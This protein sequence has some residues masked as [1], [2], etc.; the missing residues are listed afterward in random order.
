MPI[1]TVYWMLIMVG[2]FILMFILVPPLRGL[3]LSPFGF[4]LG[5]VQA[6]VLLWFGQ[7]YLKVFYFIGDPTFLGVPLLTSLTWIPLVILF[8][9]YFTKSHSRMVKLLL[10]PLFS[11]GTGMGQYTIEIIGLFQSLRWSPVYTFF[12]ALGTHSLM[13]GVLLYIRNFK[14]LRN[15]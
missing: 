2:A 12:L 6:L 9:H 5:L 10:I 11:I 7:V 14:R 1:Q 15:G 13:A 4:W 8:A 3:E